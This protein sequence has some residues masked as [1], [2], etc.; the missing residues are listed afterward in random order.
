MGREELQRPLPL[1]PATPAQSSV[2]SRLRTAANCAPP[3]PRRV[4]G[5]GGQGPARPR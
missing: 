5:R 2:Y 3:P 1:P 4:R